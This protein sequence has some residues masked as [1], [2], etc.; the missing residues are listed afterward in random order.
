[1]VFSSIIL[2]LPVSGLTIPFF[3]I[4]T[5]ANAIILAFFSIIISCVSITIH[6][7]FSNQVYSLSTYLMPDLLRAFLSSS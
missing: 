4:I 3:S 7:I 6:S 2:L 5:N 1:M